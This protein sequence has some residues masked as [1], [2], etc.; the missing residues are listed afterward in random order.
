MQERPWDDGVRAWPS[1]KFFS[2]L[3][4]LNV[5]AFMD[6][7]AG[8]CS[9]TVSST[10]CA[11]KDV[12]IIKTGVERFVL[13]ISKDEASGEITEDDIATLKLRARSPVG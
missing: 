2:K 9:F 6:N 3:D 11:M 13:Q 10:V 7:K 4:S 8:A 1:S 5:G 12:R